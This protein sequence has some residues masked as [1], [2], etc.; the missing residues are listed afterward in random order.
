[1]S[2]P[3]ITSV[4]NTE[5]ATA[6]ITKLYVNNK[7]TNPSPYQILATDLVPQASNQTITFTP[8]SETINTYD[9]TG[10]SVTVITGRDG[11]LTLE[12]VSLSDDLVVS[13]LV[14]AGN[15]IGPDAEIWFAM[16]LG[17]GSWIKGVAVVE[18]ANPL[19]PVRGA[20]RWA[21]PLK[22]TGPFKFDEIG[23]ND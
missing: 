8:Q 13:R 21:F 7:P 2:L 9:E 5:T 10:S 6:S 18:A 19:T 17:E 22:T 12:T 20:A 3:V 11:A 15:S 23:V 1:M 14:K 4:G 16:R